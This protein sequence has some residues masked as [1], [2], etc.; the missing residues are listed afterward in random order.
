MTTPEIPVCDFPG[1]SAAVSMVDGRCR[2]TVCP[3]CGHHTGNAHQGHY[4]TW[5]RVTQ[6]DREFHFCC[7]GDCELAA[8]KPPKWHDA[9][10][11][12]RKAE[13]IRN[14]PPIYCRNL[15]LNDD[16]DWLLDEITW[17]NRQLAE[18]R[19]EEETTS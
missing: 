13:G 2:C 12:Q 6:T 4:F 5:C 7:P 8:G 1:G 15:V 14:R 10:Y 3:H 19:A 11:A 18:A 17:L 9:G 16:I